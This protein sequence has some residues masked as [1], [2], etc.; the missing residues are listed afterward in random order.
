MFLKWVTIKIVSNATGYTQDALG[1]KI[2]KG[3]W[4]MGVHR[5]KAPAEGWYLA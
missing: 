2:K 3:V 4:A 1:V 5:K